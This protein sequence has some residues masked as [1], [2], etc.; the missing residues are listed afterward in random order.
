G[1][2]SDA[3]AD[4]PRPDRPVPGGDLA[5]PAA[6]LPFHAHVL[7]VRRGGDPALRRGARLLARAPAPAALPPPRG[8]GVRPRALIRPMASRWADHRRSAAPR[9]RMPGTA[10]GQ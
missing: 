8:P 5:T 2:R 1:P 9:E 6:R 4:R 10:N 3:P 7:G